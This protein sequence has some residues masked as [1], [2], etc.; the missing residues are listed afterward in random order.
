MSDAPIESKRVKSFRMSLVKE[1]PKIPN[2]R[3]TLQLLEQMSLTDLLIVYLSWRLR[4]VRQAIRSVN[5]EQ[6]A[7][8]DPRWK[9]LSTEIENFLQ[10]VKDGEDLTPYLSLQARDK[11]F[12]PA[13]SMPGRT[14][15]WTDKDF[16]MNVMGLHHFHL[17]MTIEKAGHASRTDDVLFASVSRD[18]FEVIGIFNHEV[19]ENE[20]PNAMTSERERLWKIYDARQKRG[21]LPGS[22]II[23]GFGGRGIAMSGHPTSVVMAAQKYEKSINEFDPQLDDYSYL[24]SIFPPDSVPKKQKFSWMLNGLDLCVFE[25][26]TNSRFIFEKG[27]N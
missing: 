17:G 25:K 10:K 5:I 11:G 23:G 14:N 1:I 20:D 24:K 15:T 22:L 21:A 4:F 8:N 9:L 12:A 18:V 2:D 27:P 19:F 26:S 16:L 7:M 13:A 6:T 3:A